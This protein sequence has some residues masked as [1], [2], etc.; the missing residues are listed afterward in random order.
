MLEF[1]NLAATCC[2]QLWTQL[3]LDL[4]R[5]FFFFSFQI[6]IDNLMQVSPEDKSQIPGSNKHPIS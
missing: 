5:C 1:M 4:K 6:A 3:S 2:A